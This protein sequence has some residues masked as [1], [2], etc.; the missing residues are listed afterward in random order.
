MAEHL[1]VVQDMRVQFPL[2]TQLCANRL[3]GLNW[4][5]TAKLHKLSTYAHTSQNKGG[6]S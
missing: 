6:D 4:G 3:S 1:V 5:M 2:L